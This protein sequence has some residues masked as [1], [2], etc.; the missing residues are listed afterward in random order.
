MHDNQNICFAL[1]SQIFRTFVVVFAYF[2]LFVCI[3]VQF[4]WS[5]SRLLSD[6]LFGA[7]AMPIYALQM[8]LV[9]E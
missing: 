8:K 6:A 3:S 4:H 5:L 2:A 9:Y 1:C 7:L